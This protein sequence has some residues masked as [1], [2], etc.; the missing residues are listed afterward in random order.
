MA[1]L[2]FDVDQILK[3]IKNRAAYDIKQDIRAE[4]ARLAQEHGENA[5]VS[6][7]DKT[8][9]GFEIILEN[10]S[11]KLKDDFEKFMAEDSSEV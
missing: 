11:E 3:D 10:A 9:T 2:N 7:V 6:F 5:T 4:V 8:D 1:Q